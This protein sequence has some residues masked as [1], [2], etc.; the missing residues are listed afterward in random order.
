MA[1]G[2][3]VIAERSLR[4]LDVAEE[5]HKTLTPIGGYE[6]LAL[7]TLEAAIV[8]LTVL[9]PKVEN[10]VKKAKEKYNKVSPH[11]GLTIDESASILLYTMEWD[12][13]KQSLYCVLNATL[14][15]ADRTKLAPWFLYLKLLF[16][17]LS[18]LPS[19]RRFL[20]RGINLDLLK[21]YPRNTIVTWWGLSSCAM[22]IDVPKG[23]L[24]KK[25]AGTL[26]TIDCSSGKDITYHTAYTHENEVLI[27]PETQFKVVASVDHENGL[28]M[29]QLEETRPSPC[30]LV[31]PKPL[32]KI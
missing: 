30:I 14:R 20:Y 4:F 8:P 22:T 24:G 7:V 13:P 23:F 17:A 16:T 3:K 25:S 28:C 12:L 27:L 18:R 11:D 21:D 15:S 2:G 29:V 26:F 10:Y 6:N 31:V 1:T 32:G 9:L 19:T 5:K